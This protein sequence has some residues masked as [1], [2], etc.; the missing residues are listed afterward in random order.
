VVIRSC[1]F[2]IARVAII[3][4]TLQ[5]KPR[6]MGIIDCPWRPIKNEQDRMTTIM[7]NSFIPCSARFPVF[8]IIAGAIFQNFAGVVSLG[9]YVLGILVAITFAWTFRKTLFKGDKAELIIELQPYTVPTPQSVFMKMWNQIKMFLKK[10]STIIFASVVI[11]YLLDVA[12]IMLYLGKA[13]SYAFW[14]MKTSSGSAI[15]WEYGAAIIAGLIAKEVVIGTLGTLIS[16]D[17]SSGNGSFQETLALLGPAAGIGYLVFIL[18]YTPCVATLATIKQETRSWKW[19]IFSLVFTS[20]VAYALAAA[21][22]FI[23]V[24]IISLL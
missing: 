23:A 15:G 6:I 5:P 9:L 20:I 1:S 4:G 16:G 8:V 14:W 7:V 19:T 12:G 3:A 2:L 21:A 11:I 10:A 13:V 18:L 22:Y 24:G 17:Q